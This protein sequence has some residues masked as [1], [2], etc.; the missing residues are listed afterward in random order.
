MKQENLPA[1]RRRRIQELQD[2][3]ARLKEE[4]ARLDRMDNLYWEMRNA[5][6]ELFDSDFPFFNKM[7]CIVSE[8]RKILSH[9]ID[10]V[11]SS[12]VVERQKAIKKGLGG[13]GGLQ[14]VACGPARKG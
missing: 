6:P 3:H 7:N 14:L 10:Y 2:A 13:S 4:A 8:R 5:F 9:R 11:L 1:A 12:I